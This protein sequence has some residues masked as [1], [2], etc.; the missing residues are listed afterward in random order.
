MAAGGFL[1][2]K[3]QPRSHSKARHCIPSSVLHT[4][5]LPKPAGGGEYL[6]LQVLDKEQVEQW[7]LMHENQSILPFCKVLS[8]GFF[9]HME[10]MGGEDSVA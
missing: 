9:Q 2:P 6:A 1:H 7:E 10:K 5:A 4:G 3:I 8:G